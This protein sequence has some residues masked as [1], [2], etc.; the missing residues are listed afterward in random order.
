MNTTV[1]NL[2]I[3]AAFLLGF[4]LGILVMVAREHLRSDEDEPVTKIPPPLDDDKYER[5]LARI[6]KGY[7]EA[8]SQYDR[9]VP[10][11]SGGALVV[12]MSFAGSFAPLA[13]PWTKQILAAAWVLL[14]CSLSSS[15]LSQYASTRIKVW[16]EKYVRSRQQPP[17]PEADKGGYDQWRRKTLG[18]DRRKQRNQKLTKLLNI[19]SGLLLVLGLITLGGFAIY[20]VPFG[21]DSAS[22]C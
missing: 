14:A 2:W 18:Y 17:D 5:T 3:L 22:G 11:A 1:P 16:S 13:P 19:L 7:L 8:M 6:E 12:S 21:T 20:A 15:I 9:L 10:W 4:G